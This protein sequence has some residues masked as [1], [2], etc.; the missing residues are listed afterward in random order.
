[1]QH[2]RWVCH[3]RN[4]RWSKT[5]SFGVQAACAA[6]MRALGYAGGLTPPEWLEGPQTTV[7]KDMEEPPALI[8]ATHTG[9]LRPQR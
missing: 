7:F 9:H 8:N 5:A 1:M 4:A 2:K 6:G 3:P